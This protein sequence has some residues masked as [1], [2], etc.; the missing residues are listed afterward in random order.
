MMS[1]Y[2]DL[3]YNRSVANRKSIYEDLEALRYY[4]MDVVKVRKGSQTFYYLGDRDFEVAELKF[5]V[6]AIESSKF[7]TEKKAKVLIEKLAHSVSVYDA[8]LLER[9]VKVPRPC[10]QHEREH[11]R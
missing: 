11:E 4:G 8:K 9:G 7:I 10:T 5:L 2:V 6:D 3:C 1:V